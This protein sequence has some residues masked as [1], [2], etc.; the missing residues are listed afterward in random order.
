LLAAVLLG[1]AGALVLY[2]YLP[3]AYKCPL[4]PGEFIIAWALLI[5]ITL[6]TISF[7][8]MLVAFSNPVKSLRY[9]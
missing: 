7:Q 9:E 6:A 3:G 8:A 4:Q 1:S 5:I 2:R